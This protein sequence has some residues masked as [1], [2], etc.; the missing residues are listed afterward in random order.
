MELNKEYKTCSGLTMILQG[1]RYIQE[2]GCTVQYGTYLSE[3]C[4][5]YS[6]SDWYHDGSNVY[7]PALDALLTSK[8]EEET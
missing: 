3:R 6:N 7:I 5:L 1:E 4:G 8:A 2:L